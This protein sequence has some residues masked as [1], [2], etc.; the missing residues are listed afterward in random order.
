[1]HQRKSGNGRP[2]GTDGSDFSYRMVVDSRYKKV[3]QYKSRLSIIIFI[4]AMIQLLLAV[5]LFL[6]TS[7]G[8]DLDRVAVSS[9]IICFISLLIGELGKKR[10][11][12]NFLK[13]YVFGSSIAFL[14]SIVG[15]SRS[16][17]VLQVIEDFSS[18]DSSIFELIKVA[19]GLVGVVVQI[20]TI[21]T[22]TS[23]IHNMA[24]PKRIA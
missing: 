15:L 6:S 1:M 4:Q 12:V 19:A 5:N 16:T 22:T 9:S 24:P 23:L 10:S 13:L 11:R 14:I 21:S 18:W 8:K 3:A 20:F 17:Y 2:F 7:M